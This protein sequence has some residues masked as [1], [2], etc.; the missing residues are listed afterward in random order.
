MW[1]SRSEFQAHHLNVQ[2]QYLGGTGQWLLAKDE[3][4]EWQKSSESSILWLHVIRM[5]YLR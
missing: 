3:F 4:R 2:S 5:I 1:L